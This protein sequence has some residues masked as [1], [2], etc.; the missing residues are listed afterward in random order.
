MKL[1]KV[2]DCFIFNDEIG[3]LELRIKYLSHSVDEFIIF[4]SRK[5]FSGKSKPL[6]ARNHRDQLQKLSNTQISFWEARINNMDEGEFSERWPIEFETRRQFLERIISERPHDRIIFGDVDEI[7]SIH[8][9]EVIR[10]LC[11]VQDVSVYG[12]NMPNYYK[13]VNWYVQGVGERMN[14]PKTFVGCLP[15]PM[16]FLRTLDFFEDIQGVGAH[17][18]YLGMS[19]HQVNKKFGEFSHREYS[20]HEKIEDYIQRTQDRFAIDHIGRYFFEERG[21]IKIV[22][23]EDLPEPSRFVRTQFPSYFKDMELPSEFQR[24]IAS[25]TVTLLR[26]Y[27]MSNQK[28]ALNILLHADGN[29]KVFSSIFFHYFKVKAICLVVADISRQNRVSIRG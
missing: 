10:D 23:F 2:I 17:L 22:K 18:S 5:T 13:Y 27:M 21:L 9:V 29:L 14:A 25:A 3:L 4:E 8:Q 6:Y 11:L 7:P 16:E 19:T 24:L 20:G 28:R 1:G 26:R 15:P 12:I